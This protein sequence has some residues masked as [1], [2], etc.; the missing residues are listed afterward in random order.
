MQCQRHDVQTSLT[1]GMCGVP[2]CSKCA[3]QTPVG[4]KCRGCAKLRRSPVYELTPV[5]FL[6]GAGAGIGL[7]ILIGIAW[8]WLGGISFLGF[9]LAAAAG[10]A[11]AEVISISVNRKRGRPLQALAILCV[12]I[13]FVV[14]FVGLSP[15]GITFFAAFTP[16]YLLLLVLAAFVA[17]FRL[18]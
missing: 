11:I 7:S 12:S 2:I 13:A 8:G 1:C 10:Y 15:G 3:V 4:Y 14:S 6:R 16:M 9:L 5:H 17:V 18:Q